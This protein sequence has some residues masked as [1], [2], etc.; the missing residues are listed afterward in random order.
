MIGIITHNQIIGSHYWKDAPVQYAYLRNLH[1]HVFT[2]R[3]KFEVS[4][5]DREIEINDMQD[6]IEDAIKHKFGKSVGIGAGVC[7]G[8]MSCEQIATWCIDYFGC[9]ECEVLE[10]GFGGAYARN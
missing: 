8:G 7:F 1:R 9:T 10:D 5:E 6:T 3:C 4:H 2:I